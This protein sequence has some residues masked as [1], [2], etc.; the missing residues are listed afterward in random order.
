[1][2]QLNF[3][4]NHAFQQSLLAYFTE[5]LNSE[6]PEKLYEACEHYLGQPLT[7]KA[8]EEHSTH[9]HYQAVKALANK[10]TIHLD[11]IDVIGYHGQTLLHQPHR[12]QSIQLGDAHLLHAL[13]GVN[14]VYQFRQQDLEHGGQGA[15]FAPLYHRALAMRDNVLPCVIVNCGGIANLTIIMGHDLG[16]LYAFDA[17]PGNCLLDNFVRLR[18]QGTQ[19]MDVDGRLAKAGRFNPIL[20]EVLEKHSYR[21]I[22]GNYYQRKPPKSL[23][24]N[25][26]QLPSEF[27]GVDIADGAATLTYFTIKILVESIKFV[28][29][30]M[31]NHWILAGGGFN[32]PAMLAFLRQQLPA[33]IKLSTAKTLGWD[34]DGLEAEI[35]A[36]LAAR[37]LNQLPLSLPL[38]TGV[39]EEQTG[40][41]QIK[42][43][44]SS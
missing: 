37:S 8:I 22:E 13:T 5:Q 23:D 21:G 34:G 36:Y 20:L 11:N 3:I 19:M 16:Q 4:D 38:T 43:N 31:P 27:N 41:I 24:V 7:L 6:N 44:I 14:V 26:F 25:D 42:S 18:T 12:K 15:P 2:Q 30:V 1:M 33:H 28:T 10:L 17:G 40:G 35:F 32:N 29:D 39:R 9:L